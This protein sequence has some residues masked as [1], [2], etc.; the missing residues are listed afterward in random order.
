MGLTMLLAVLLVW[1]TIFV[2][3]VGVYGSFSAVT[4]LRPPGGSPAMFLAGTAVSKLGTAIAFV[5]IFH[6]ARDVIGDM[7][8]LYAGIWWL[9]FVLDEIGRGTS[10][11]DGLALAHAIADRLLAHN[12]SLAL[13][14]THYFELTAIAARDPHAVNLHL[15]AAEHRK[16]IVFLHEVRDGPASGINI[17][18]TTAKP[19]RQP[20]R[21]C[22][23][24]QVA[25]FKQSSCK[26]AGRISK[27]WKAARRFPIKVQQHVVGSVRRS[28]Y[29]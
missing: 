5:A 10:T 23:M 11:F 18:F 20:V 26:V 8:L 29:P 13:F 7:W 27:P 15:A 22:P 17:A 6:L 21:R 2:V 25:N 14:A 4:G 24:A 16:G 19:S 3:P 9:M 28:V 12:R 1:V